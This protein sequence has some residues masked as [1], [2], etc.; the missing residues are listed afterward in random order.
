MEGLRRELGEYFRTLRWEEGDAPYYFIA[1]ERA[2]RDEMIERA[3][4]TV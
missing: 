3:Q 1:L 2:V 4:M